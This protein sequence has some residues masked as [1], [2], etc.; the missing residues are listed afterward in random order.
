MFSVAWKLLT[1]GESL[2]ASAVVQTLFFTPLW[3]AEMLQGGVSSHTWD[4][5]QDV[6]IWCQLSAW[7]P[8]KL[9]ALF[10]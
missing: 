3:G 7:F 8:W 5:I 4:F 2:S 6:G 9:V 10:Q 1:T